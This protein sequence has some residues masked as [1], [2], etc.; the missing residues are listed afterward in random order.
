[1]D[2]PVFH[3]TITG[4]LAGPSAGI[5]PNDQIGVQLGGPIAPAFVCLRALF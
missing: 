1:M 4:E 2:P 5:Q 3:V